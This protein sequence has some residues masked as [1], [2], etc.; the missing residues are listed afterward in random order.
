MQERGKTRKSQNS[1]KILL[2]IST[3]NPKKSEAYNNIHQNI[4][5]IQKEPRL[6]TIL[7]TLRIIRSNRQLKYLKRVL[8]NAKLSTKI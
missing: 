6:Y 1:L 8:T 5:P 2:Y 3:L 4:P 7:D